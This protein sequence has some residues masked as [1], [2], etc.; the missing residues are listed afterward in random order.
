MRRSK[1]KLK[2]IYKITKSI[3]KE[4]PLTFR[5]RPRTY[6]D[7][8]II[9]VFLYQ[10]LKNLSYREVLEETSDI[11]GKRPALSTYH[12]RV[13]K[14]PEQMLKA[15]LHELALRLLAKEKV[16][17]LICDGT[18]FSYQDIYPLRLLRGSEVKKIKAH[19][20]IV[21]IIGITESKKR[22][23]IYAKT[24]ASYT[25]EVKLLLKE[26]KEVD[27]NL[28][29]AE[30]LIADRCY[31]SIKVMERLT[32]MG[33]KPAIKVKESFRQ[34]IRH[35]LRKESKLLWERWGK[36]RYLVES[37]FGTIK[38]KIGSHFAVKKVEIARKRALAAFV[39][40]FCVYFILF[41]CLYSL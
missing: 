41:L 38:Q 5:G 21:P 2:V 8:F 30:C 25:S 23:I 9:S 22:I 3:I 33:L 7:V 31:D 1:L 14:L 39:I 40:V 18:G 15:L 32:D 36:N 11:L 28:L 19:I 4:K 29:K 12:Y 13:S 35:P 34:K 26:L 17:F 6:S 20:R 37:L 24:A 10:T 16:R 27:L